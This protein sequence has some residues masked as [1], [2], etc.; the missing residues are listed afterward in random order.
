MLIPHAH[1]TG[2]GRREL[3]QVGFSVFAGLGLGAG[4]PRLSASD[5]SSRKPGRAKQV[6][7]IFQTGAP[8]HIDTFDPKPDAPVEVR[9]EFTTIPTTIPGV[10]FGEHL[11]LLAA[12]ARQMAVVRTFSHKDNNHTAATHHI[13]TGALQPGVRFDKPLSR[14]TTGPVTHRGSRSAIRPRAESRPE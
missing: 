2:I 9:G 14:T 10:R 13:I 5:G 1:S 8:S 12:R 7:L 4:I 6:L 11:P 3:L